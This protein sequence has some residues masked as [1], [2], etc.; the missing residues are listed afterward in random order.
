MAGV[1][2]ARSVKG[3]EPVTLGRDEAYIGVL[4][5]D[6]V[7]KGVDEPYRMFTSRAEYRILLRRDDADM[8]LTP[9][10]YEIG[11][12]TRERY[13]AMMS[14][15]EER[16]ALI[17]W[18]RNF[19][20]KMGE[21]INESLKALGTAP[22]SASVKLYDLL[23]RPHLD[24]SNLAPIIGRLRRRIEEIEARE[25]RGD[26]GERGDTDKVWRLYR[27]RAGTGRESEEARICETA[28]RY[29][30]SHSSLALNRGKAETRQR[31]APPR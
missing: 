15:K 3:E 6:L 4:I 5:D 22:L 28:R 2:A 13:D 10:G 26:C 30:L 17:E 8:R 23:K 29:Q 14:K 20:V 16:D 31:S 24:F 7:T 25:E 12:A 1:N 9:K 21:K 27:Q 11:L 18:C 19:T